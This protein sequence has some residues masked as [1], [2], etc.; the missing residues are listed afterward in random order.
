MFSNHVKIVLVAV[1]FNILFEYSMRGAGGFALHKGFMLILPVIYFSYFMI[2]ESLI[3]KYRITNKQLF[4]VA[5]CFGILITTFFSGNIFAGPALLGINWPWFLFVNI[6]WWGIIQGLLTFY[7]ATRIVKRD[8]TEES[9]G[10]RGFVLSSAV[11][12]FFLLLAFFTGAPKGLP[13]GYITSIVLF[14][15]AFRYLRKRLRK[16]QQEPYEVQRSRFLD[17]LAFGTAIVFFLSGT[18]IATSQMNVNASLISPEA[19]RLM[20]GWTALMA[21]GVAGYYIKQRKQITI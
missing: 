21:V 11:I 1:V 14:L 10:R 12:L 15:I 4:A 8:W 20:I 16:P 18:F 6:V 3:R 9:M 2:V 5:F 17:V 7:L 13:I 19:L